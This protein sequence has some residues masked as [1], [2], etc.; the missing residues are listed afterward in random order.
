MQSAIQNVNELVKTV[1][2]LEG[3]KKRSGCG[4]FHN[5]DAQNG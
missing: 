4:H 2:T 5:T 3:K 1:A